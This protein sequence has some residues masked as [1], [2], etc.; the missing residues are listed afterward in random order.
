V[1]HVPRYMVIFRQNIDMI[2]GWLINSSDDSD[3][4]Y[5]CHSVRVTNAIYLIP[6]SVVRADLGI[7]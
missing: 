7:K 3:V 5:L 2:S 4:V 6:K 1:G